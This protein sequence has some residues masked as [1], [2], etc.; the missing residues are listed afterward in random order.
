MNASQLAMYHSS[1]DPCTVWVIAPFPMLQ[2]LTASILKQQGML[3]LG[4]SISTA[5]AVDSKTNS[6]ISHYSTGNVVGQ[7]SF[8]FF[9]A[10]LNYISQ[11]QSVWGRWSVQQR[12][13]CI[14]I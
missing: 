7:T 4:N 6:N 2:W 5:F 11:D 8:F 9:F 14:N 3:I 1:K 12:L 10:N 13:N